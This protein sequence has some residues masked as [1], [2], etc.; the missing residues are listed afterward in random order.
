LSSSSVSSAYGAAVPAFDNSEPY[1]D[2]RATAVEANDAKTAAAIP[3]A[4]VPMG[5][6]MFSLIP[7]CRIAV[8]P[9]P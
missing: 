4:A 6:D 5:V 2:L 9:D 3:Q 7:S 8:A 1:Y